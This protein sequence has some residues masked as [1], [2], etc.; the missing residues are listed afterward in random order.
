VNP[1]YPELDVIKAAAIV[2]V[3]LI[4]SVRPV[5]VPG[6]S[7][8]EEVILRVTRF[9]V[10]AFLTVSGF[11]YYS[12]TPL[13]LRTL[14]RRYR[15]LLMPYLCVSLAAYVYGR[16]FPQHLVIPSLWEALLVGGTFGPYYYVFVLATLIPFTWVLSRLPWPALLG[17]TLVAVLATVHAQVSWVTGQSG[18]FWRPISFWAVRSPQVWAGWFVSGWVAAAGRPRV[19]AFALRYRTWLLGLWSALIAGWIGIV[20]TPRVPALLAGFADLGVTAA[21]IAGLLVVSRGI[22]K[23]PGIMNRLSSWTYP[24][25]LLHPFFVYASQ[26]GLASQLGLSPLP[27]ALVSWC[28]GL[29]GGIVVTALVRRVAGPYS[30][31]LVGA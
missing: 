28:A 20:C 10:P 1:R 2:A 12:A 3:V 8:W 31:D 5:F 25:Y 22:T 9:A 16:Q 30:R 6:L 17:V 7:L 29:C 14:A 21:N 23:L 24:L 18:S 26:D 13:D 4:H 19:F 11:L 27:S 15:R